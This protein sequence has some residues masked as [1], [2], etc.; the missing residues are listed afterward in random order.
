MVNG[1]FWCGIGALVLNVF[2]TP[3]KGQMKPE[4]I[5]LPF[6]FFAAALTGH[7]LAL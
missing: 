5:V 2:F 6:T 7:F 4:L 3:F 1:L